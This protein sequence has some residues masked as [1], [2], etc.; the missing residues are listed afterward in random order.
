MSSLRIY[1]CLL[2]IFRLVLV[3][4]EWRKEQ[5]E[6]E[7]IVKAKQKIIEVQ[8]K[9]IQTLDAT[10]ARLVKALTQT[11]RSNIALEPTVNGHDT[12]VNGRQSNGSSNPAGNS[13]S[14][15]PDIIDA[16]NDTREE[17][18]V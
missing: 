14:R 9:R 10:N 17:R 1:T 15:I 7:E 6:M 8:E 2:L 16:H 3:E 18:H 11:T 5:L 13:T 12:N 4:S